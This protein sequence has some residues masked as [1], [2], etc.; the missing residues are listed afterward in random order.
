MVAFVVVVALCI[1][2]PLILFLSIQ[3]NL[4]LSV[5]YSRHLLATVLANWSDGGMITSDL[6]DNSDEVQL[7]GLLDILQRMES[8]ELFEKVS[9]HRMFLRNPV[10]T[11]PGKFE[12]ASFIL[13]HTCSHEQTKTLV[14]TSK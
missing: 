12:N 14:R 2:R 11:K 4:A 5:I 9:Q 7:I 8:K 1:D 10:H 6:L 3:V 13:V